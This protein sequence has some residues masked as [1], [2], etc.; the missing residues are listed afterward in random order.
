[1]WRGPSSRGGKAGRWLAAGALRAGLHQAHANLETAP[2]PRVVLEEGIDLQAGSGRQRRGGD[3][4]DVTPSGGRRHT[5]QQMPSLAL[6]TAAGVTLARR[7]P[8]VREGDADRDAV[9]AER[10]L[11]PGRVA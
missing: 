5:A 11:E 3:D 6:A 4:H 1:M 10:A 7:V 8:L 9:G 2:W